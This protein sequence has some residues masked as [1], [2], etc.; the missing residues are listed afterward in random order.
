MAAET[1]ENSLSKDQGALNLMNG[2]DLQMKTLSSEIRQWI[3]KAKGKITGKIIKTRY[4]KTDV[5]YSFVV[6]NDG[7]LYDFDSF[8]KPATPTKRSRNHE[9]IPIL[10]SLSLPQQYKSL[11]KISE[12]YSQVTLDFEVLNLALKTSLAS[13]SFE[14]SLDLDKI[15]DQEEQDYSKEVLEE[16]AELSEKLLKTEKERLDKQI[17]LISTKSQVAHELANLKEL[18]SSMLENTP[19]LLPAKIRKSD[20]LKNEEGVVEQK[21]QAL[22]DEKDR[23]QEMR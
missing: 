23:V 15:T 7:V 6:F 9:K 19:D 1:L 14:K 3:T 8:T 2:V 11:L 18:F 12:E 10:K 16:N 17:D 20:D 13:K 22:L 4:Q 21:E 5:N